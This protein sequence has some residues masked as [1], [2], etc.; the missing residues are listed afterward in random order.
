MSEVSGDQFEMPSSPM[1]IVEGV[2]EQGGFVITASFEEHGVVGFELPSKISSTAK[3]AVIEYKPT[4]GMVQV[5]VQLLTVSLP[6]VL[7]DGL[8]VLFNCL[9]L[10]VPAVTLTVSFDDDEGDQLEMSI[11]HL[12]VSDTL[13]EANIE[14]LVQYLEQAV[15]LC[16]PLI[17][18]YLTQRLIYRMLVGGELVEIKT[19]VSPEDCLDMLR[20]KK[21]GIA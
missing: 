2:L 19:T 10:E 21:H 12:L 1:D 4:L 8:L 20:I 18:S 14:R 13:T 5:T 15:E 6:N 16:L 11:A 7:R 3:Q 9:H 17:Y